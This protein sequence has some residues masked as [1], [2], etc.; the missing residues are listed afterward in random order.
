M[1]RHLDENR[2]RAGVR[3]IMN[4]LDPFVLF[5]V[6]EF[7]AVTALLVVWLDP[8]LTCVHFALCGHITPELVGLHDGEPPNVWS[9][10]ET[11]KTPECPACER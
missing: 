6:V 4:L 7:A 11:G 5:V 10:I 8:R 3:A 2:L 1:R 9:L